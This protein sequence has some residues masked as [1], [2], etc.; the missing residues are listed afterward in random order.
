[1]GRCGAGILAASVFGV[2]AV[3]F[4]AGQHVEHGRQQAMKDFTDGEGRYRLPDRG[5]ASLVVTEV[6]ADAVAGFVQ[7]PAVVY[8]HGPVDA[9]LV[10]RRTVVA[11]RRG[12]DGRLFG[13]CEVD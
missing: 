2:W 3:A 1:V 13:E 11:W 4:L 5:A 7:I 8:L 6:R 12:P 9:A 10:G